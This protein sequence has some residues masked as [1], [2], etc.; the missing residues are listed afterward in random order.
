MAEILEF[1]KFIKRFGHSWHIPLSPQT[2][3]HRGNYSYTKFD[4]SFVAV[5]HVYTC[6]AYFG[7]GHALF[8]RVID[9]QPHQNA[10]QRVVVDCTEFAFT[11]LH[12]FFI[13]WLH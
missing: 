3:L 7:A 12:G 6:I 13:E 9:Q 11:A 10:F 8:K 5:H 4:A 2:T 1:A